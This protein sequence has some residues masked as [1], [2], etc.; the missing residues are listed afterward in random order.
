[1]AAVPPAAGQQQAFAEGEHLHGEADVDRELEHEPL[2]VVTGWPAE[3]RRPAAG[4][5]RT[6]ADEANGGDAV[7]VHLQERSQSEC[8]VTSA[9][10]ANLEPRLPHLLQFKLASREDPMGMLSVIR[11]TSR[12]D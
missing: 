1:M 4:P 7:L 2:A 6:E 12:P 3:R 5:H 11:A 8:R 9:P 10:A